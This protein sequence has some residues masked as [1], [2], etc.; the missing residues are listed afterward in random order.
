MNLS[1]D[2]SIVDTEKKQQEPR[3]NL[4]MLL[5]HQMYQPLLSGKLREFLEIFLLDIHCYVLKTIYHDYKYFIGQR[6]CVCLQ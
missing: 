6:F 2:T 3:Q 1:V 5:L 4:N